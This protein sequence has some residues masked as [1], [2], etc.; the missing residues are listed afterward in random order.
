MSSRHIVDAVAK[1]VDPSSLMQRVCDETLELISTS[2]GV[3]IGL[4]SDQ[5]I[6]YVCGAG[7]GSASVGA[8]VDMDA[9]LSGLAMRSGQIVQSCNTQNDPRVDAVACRALSVVSL[10]CIP[11]S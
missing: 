11:L 9:S 4:V 1:A 3:A 7:A 8:T 5:R 2:D 6:T 10:V